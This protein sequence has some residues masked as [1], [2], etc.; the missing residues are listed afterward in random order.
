MAFGKS[1]GSV[2]DRVS[3]KTSKKSS[4]TVEYSIKRGD[5]LIREFPLDGHEVSGVE[6]CAKS[7]REVQHR[8]VHERIA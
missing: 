1:Y 7:Q 2:S 5:S 4:K 6:R 8:T 3:K